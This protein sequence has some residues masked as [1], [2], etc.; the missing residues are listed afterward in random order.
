MDRLFE[1]AFL[2]LP[3]VFDT[4]AII[5][6]NGTGVAGAILA[7]LQ[8]RIVVTSVVTGELEAGVAKGRSDHPKFLDLVT[9]KIVSVEDLSD[10]AQTTFQDLVTG[11]AIE[12]LDDGEA[13]TL[14]HALDL[15]A[16]AVIDEKK[17]RR[18]AGDRFPSLSILTTTD[19]LHHPEMEKH[20]GRDSLADAI[21]AA[22][23]VARMQVPPAHLQWVR[24]LLG[25][26]VNQCPSLPRS[27]RQTIR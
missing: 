14:A 18:I 10:G 8:R 4:S 19:L 20:V 3:L 21:F 16:V 6:L 12:T 2:D 11:S 5:N 26:R 7:R 15:G 9:R 17:A 24:D 13:A 23:T 1:P 22:L 27:S 25:A